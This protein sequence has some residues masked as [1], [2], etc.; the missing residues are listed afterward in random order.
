MLNLV[1]FK[2]KSSK[3][4]EYPP[5]LDNDP[6]MAAKSLTKEDLP[7]AYKILKGAFEQI[8]S[9]KI[10]YTILVDSILNS[11]EN[12]T[13]FAVFFKEMER[14]LGE[15]NFEIPYDDSPEPKEHETLEF[16][17]PFTVVQNRSGS[18]GYSVNY[19]RKN[20]KEQ[21]AINNYRILYIIA[22]Y[23]MAE[24]QNDEYPRW[25]LFKN[26]TVF[27]QYNVK[28]NTRVR[29]DFMNSE[30]QYYVAGASDNWQPIPEVPLEMDDVV[31]ALL[32]RR[33]D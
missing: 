19:S 27:E 30:F 4:A 16:Q 23:D 31:S 6:V 12:F 33:I 29:I 28:T 9:D 14:I 2:I 11:A 21:D 10:E 8:K 3:E 13:W 24:F 17:Q 32:I 22:Q 1:H 18:K 25:Y 5:I 15:E 20:V 7:K 26:T